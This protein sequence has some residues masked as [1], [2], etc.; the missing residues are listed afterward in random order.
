VGGALPQQRRGQ[1]QPISQPVKAS[2]CSRGEARAELMRPRGN[3]QLARDTD[4]TAARNTRLGRALCVSTR[5]RSLRPCQTRRDP[6][7]STPHCNCAAGSTELPEAW[8]K[9]LAPPR[10]S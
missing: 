9:Y 1:P 4:A 5:R 2:N 3:S 6:Q 8:R 10:V 7:G